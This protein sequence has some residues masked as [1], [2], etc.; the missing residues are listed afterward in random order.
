MKHAATRIVI[1]VV[2]LSALFSF[3][4]WKAAQESDL[5]EVP[6]DVPLLNGAV[7]LGE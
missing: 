3:L 1:L 6:Q 5:E 7:E 4:G 2:L